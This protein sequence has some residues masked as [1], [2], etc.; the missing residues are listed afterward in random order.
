LESDAFYKLE[1]TIKDEIIQQSRA[2]AIK[3]LQKF[4]EQKW[5]DP[6]EM[7]RKMRGKFRQEKL[8]IKK[9]LEERRT[10]KDGFSLSID[11]LPK[12]DVDDEIAKMVGHQRKQPRRGCG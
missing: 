4:N 11:V 6:F 2:P 8:E 5:S 12:S 9:D 1:N 7:S 10:V 3:D